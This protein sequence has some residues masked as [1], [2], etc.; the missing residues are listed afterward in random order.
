MQ[1]TWDITEATSRIM[2]LCALDTHQ[3]RWYSW[4]IE[5]CRTWVTKSPYGIVSQRW[6]I[7]LEKYSLVPRLFTATLVWE[8]DPPSY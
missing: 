8:G 2:G 1:A 4:Q 5:I 6:G 3:Q 7:Q